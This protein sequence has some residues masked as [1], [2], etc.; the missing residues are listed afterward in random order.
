MMWLLWYVSASGLCF[1]Y[2]SN[3]AH[4]ANTRKHS[5]YW[6]KTVSVSKEFTVYWERKPNT[7]FIMIKCNKCYNRDTIHTWC[8]G[9]TE[10]VVSPASWGGHKERARRKHSSTRQCMICDLRVSTHKKRKSGAT[11][12]ERTILHKDSRCQRAY[13]EDM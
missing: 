1:V 6:N 13:L 3:G 2:C 12:A 10:K 4:R 8:C 9:H 5:G 7:H 11:K